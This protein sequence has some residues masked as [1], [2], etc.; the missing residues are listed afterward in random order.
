[1]DDQVRGILN[2]H[3]GA[4]HEVDSGAAAVDGLVARHQELPLESDGHAVDEDDP[5]RLGSGHSVAQSVGR[6]H[7]PVVLVGGDDVEVAV[8]AALSVRSKSHGTRCQHL[9]TVSPVG[10]AAPAVID[11]VSSQAWQKCLVTANHV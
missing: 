6:W 5:E 2:A 9:A 1:M 10:V 7:L 11:V 4:A 3:L 8:S